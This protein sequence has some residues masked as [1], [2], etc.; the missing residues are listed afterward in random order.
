MRMMPISAVMAEP[1][2]PVTINAV[3]TGPSSRMRESATVG[4]SHPS[5][6]NFRSV[7]YPWSA[8]TIPVNA[9]VSTMMPRDSTPTKWTWRTMFRTR[10]G[11]DTARAREPP[12]NNPILPRYRVRRIAQDPIESAIARPFPV[13][14]ILLEYR[15]RL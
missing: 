5:E 15:E 13:P 11:G 6:P 14:I 2:R 3:S 8:R 4:P 12:R 10:Y 1:A 9:A 7:T